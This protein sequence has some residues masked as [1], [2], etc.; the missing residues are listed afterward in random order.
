MSGTR[1]IAALSLHFVLLSGGRAAPTPT[2]WPDPGAVTPP[3]SQNVVRPEGAPTEGQD[4]RTW[5]VL[6]L[7]YR[8]TDAPYGSQ[9]A[10]VSM[11]ANQVAMLQNAAQNYISIVNLWSASL[12]KLAVSVQ[13]VNRPLATV[14]SVFNDY[15]W[16]T[17]DDVA[18]ELTAAFGETNYDS[19][20]AMWH[21]GPIPTNYWGLA[22]VG[23]TEWNGHP[24]TWST[25]LMLDD[26][27][28]Q[29]STPGE[30]ILHEW[31][32]GVEGL[33]RN[34][35]YVV[36]EL[37]GAGDHGYTEDPGGGWRTWYTDFMQGHVIK[38][39]E[40]RGISPAVWASGAVLNRSAPAPAQLLSPL[41]SASVASPP[42]LKWAGPSSVGCRPALENT[43]DDSPAYDTLT[44]GKTI[45]VPSRALRSNQTYSWRVPTEQGG[46][47]KPAPESRTFIYAGPTDPYG[48]SEVGA[49]LRGFA[50]LS[51]VSAEDMGRWNL[52]T[53]AASAGRVDLQDVTQVLRKAAGL[54]PNP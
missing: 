38:G 41:P 46:V 12:G 11:T 31:L 9:R 37:H 14:T 32:H 48:L 22:Y 44:Y 54:D 43:A 4:P 47:I 33:Y 30:V 18:P 52:T 10:T 15:Y 19:I 17:P 45:T 5:K 42:A 50:G 21:S 36:P 51:G 2:G 16:L 26:W 25:V 23:P 3:P 28:W 34:Y 8:N 24:I 53:A 7:I 49:A 35:G 39:G 27:L 6:L 20:I 13:V 40:T 29:G 1:C